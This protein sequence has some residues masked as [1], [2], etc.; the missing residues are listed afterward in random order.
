MRRRILEFG[1]LA[2]IFLAAGGMGGTPPIPRSLAEILLFALGLLYLVT[3]PSTAPRAFAKLL[4]LPLALC[5]W[6]AF[7][8]F[9]SRR[10]EIGLDPYSIE[11]RG[12]VVVACFVAFFLALEASRERAARTR[13]VLAL[14]A[15]GLL[16]SFYGLA[17]YFGGWQYIWNTPRRY[18]LGSASGTFINHNHFAG[19]LEMILPLALALALYHAQKARSHARPRSRGEFLGDLG[20]PHLLKCLLLLL[21]STILFLGIFFSFSRMGMISMLASLALLAAA[22]L[23]GRSR[24]PQPVGFIIVL[25]VCGI[26]TAAW[27]GAAPVVE[28]FEALAHGDPLER[29][30]EGRRVLWSDALKLVGAHPFAG[31][32]LGCFEIAFASVQSAELDYTIDHA[33]NDYLEFAVEL[34]LP[35]AALLF[36]AFFWLV[37]RALQAAYLARSGLSRAHALGAACGVSALLV[38]SLADFNLQIPA[39]ALV[40]SALLGLGSAVSLEL[41]AELAKSSRDSASAPLAQSQR[42]QAPMSAAAQANLSV[43]ESQQAKALE[44]IEVPVEVPVEL[45][46]NVPRSN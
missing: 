24:N 37:A 19:L 25:V 26:A 30:A 15:L 11:S 20:R 5:A 6:I 36:A 1:L 28:H 27:L 40:F 22:V 10:G 12:L 3:A 8:W 39:N 13:F 41:R 38:H 4:P 33:H 21:A 7:Q 17:Q 29:G 18:Y 14:I 43:E 44:E 2:A 34:G 45:R 32:G 16:E 23:L 35:A 46:V 42:A 31:S 9:A